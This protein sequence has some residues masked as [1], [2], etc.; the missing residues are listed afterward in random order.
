MKTMLKFIHVLLKI[1]LKKTP[2]NECLKNVN[3]RF[4]KSS[5]M[6]IILYDKNVDFF[7]NFKYLYENLKHP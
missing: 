3:K 2:M 6:K 5:P 7:L 4:N 1:L